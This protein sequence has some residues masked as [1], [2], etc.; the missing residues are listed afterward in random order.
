MR[1]YERA[2]ICQYLVNLAGRSPAEW[3]QLWKQTHLPHWFAIYLGQLGLDAGFVR[4]TRASLMKIARDRYAHLNPHEDAA[5]ASHEEVFEALNGGATSIR[6]TLRKYLRAQY[7]VKLP[8]RPSTI[9]KRLDWIG[10]LINLSQAERDILGLL[11]RTALIEP[12]QRLIHALHSEFD[13]GRNSRISLNPED[14]N[15]RDI[16]HLL[17]FK[18][19]DVQSLLKAHRSLRIFEMVEDRHGYDYTVS[20]AAQEI[21]A[22][23]QLKE[24]R[25]REMFLGKPRRAILDWADFA[26]LGAD[27]DLVSDLIKKGIEPHRV[28]RRLQLLREWSRHEQDNEQVFT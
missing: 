23:P 15:A 24:E 25:V 14:V 20:G 10:K 4:E 26:H 19:M 2:M 9:Q 16:C 13:Q 1:H 22:A 17:N 7:P 18:P 3:K 6:N 12:M 5:Q 21:V 8:A 28:C 11:A 27:A